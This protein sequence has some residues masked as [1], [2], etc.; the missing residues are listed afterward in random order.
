MDFKDIVLQ[1]S[2]RA[3]KLKDSL[4]TE[5]ATKTSLVLPFIQALGYDFFN[6]HEVVPE[7][8]CDIG[9]KKGE[10]IDY[11]ILK[12]GKPIILIE[13]KQCDQDLNL[14]DNQLLRYFH[15]SS[16][17][18]GILTNGVIYR[19]Y[20]DLET[21]NKM[22]EKPFLEID[23]IN[24]RPNQIDEL[25]KF[26]KSYFDVSN[27]LSSASELK[28]TNE[29][30]AA[31][32]KEFHDPSPDF[33]KY[34][35]KQ[36]YDGQFT[37]RVQELFTEFVKKS[38]GQYIDELVNETL[39]SALKSRQKK[40]EPVEQ[41]QSDVAESEKS[42][43]E[44]TEEELEGYMIVKA[45]LHP[46]IDVSRIVYRDA[47]SYFA[48]LFDDN[49]RKPICRLYFNGAK[50]YITTFDENKKEARHDVSSLNDIY[51]SAEEIKRIV[52]FY[53]GQA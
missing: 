18:F 19:F 50:K 30:K 39:A 28:Y 53:K 35:T 41:Q 2:E 46:V 32:D 27:I 9:T 15:V 49:N 25:K 47:Q 40:D 21:P 7:F 16:S 31:L 43:I 1:L 3:N 6:P 29:I 24:P 52:E 44:T 8:T 42:L 17:K 20:T 48:I 5:E 45:I 12:D 23:M 13:C 38:I 37:A 34:F 51:N 36:V 14:H 10:K 11:A 4:S 22:D 33:V 26:H